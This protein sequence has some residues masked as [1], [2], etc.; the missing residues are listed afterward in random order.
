VQVFETMRAACGL[1]L[2][3]LAGAGEARAAA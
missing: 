3:A 1:V 2:R